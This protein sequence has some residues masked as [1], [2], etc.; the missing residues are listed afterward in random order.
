MAL[1][2]LAAHINQQLGGT[3]NSTL[4]HFFIRNH[5]FVLETVQIF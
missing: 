1:Q 4:K 3:H 5:A 2:Q